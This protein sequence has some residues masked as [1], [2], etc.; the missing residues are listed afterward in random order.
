M[1]FLRLT[2]LFS[3]LIVL[4]FVITSGVA[5]DIRNPV[6][7]G[8][9][10]S[11]EPKKLD[12]QISRLCDQAVSES[13]LLFDQGSLKALIL[14]HA[15]YLYSGRT[16]AH[17]AR[18]LQKGMF[19]KVILI[20][21]DH[22]VGFEGGVISAVSAY[23]TPLGDIPL[24]PDAG[25]LLKNK[26]LFQTN[27][28]SDE[29]EHS[30]EVV[31]PFL[32]HLL[33]QFSLVPIVLGPGRTQAVGEA[34]SPLL[35]ARTL[36]V[37]SSD[38]SHYLSYAAAKKQDLSTVEAILNL[39]AT[40]LDKK[41]SAC[42]QYGIQILIGLARQQ[43]W[44]PVLLNYSNSGDTAGQKERVVG[45]GAIAFFQEKDTP[46]LHKSAGLTD[47]QGQ[48]IVQLARQTLLKSL[49]E[50]PDPADEKLLAKNLQDE[51]FKNKRATF[52]T[53]NSHGNLRGCIGSLSARRTLVEDVRANVLHV[54]YRDSRFNPLQ[55][56]ELNRISIE[57]SILTPPVTL[58]YTGPADLLRKLRPHID[59]VILRRGIH[60]STY[61]PQVW[62][63]L[64]DA[65]QFL[66]RLCLKAN[67]PSDA[68]RTEKLEVQVYQVQHF[69]E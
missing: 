2:L 57:V 69:N 55:K 9:F 24:H 48:V 20:G 47:K 44:K 51:V 32:Q 13:S 21:P 45:Y 65:E 23:Q 66:S 41:N 27:S 67:L 38:L 64:A 42:G 6:W 29:S 52:V 40:R 11:A 53:L 39:D 30:L 5:G 15:G 4:C 33:G 8:K 36:L 49:G 43:H 34:I 58:K 68:W 12:A 56:E 19:D 35:D 62:E 18:V 31:L 17:A 1:L 16:A 28:V 37:I 7:A 22:N 26:D 10:Y 59:G 63:Q 54:A 25:R 3:S 50:S 46:V 14:P 61:L 60:S